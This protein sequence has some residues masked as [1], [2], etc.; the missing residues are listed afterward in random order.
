MAHARREIHATETD[1]ERPGCHYSQ[2]ADFI[3]ILLSRLYLDSAPHSAQFVRSTPQAQPTPETPRRSSEATHHPPIRCMLLLNQRACAS[4]RERDRDLFQLGRKAGSRRRKGAAHGC[5]PS[6]FFA[7]PIKATVRRS[8]RGAAP[9]AQWRRAACSCWRS[10]L[11][12]PRGFLHWS[13]RVSCF[14]AHGSRRTDMARALRSSIRVR[15]RACSTACARG[16]T[17]TERS[18]CTLSIRSRTPACKSCMR[19]RECSWR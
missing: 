10:L 11:R 2:F 13:P 9:R 6:V 18:R 8:P 12:R 15:P 3:L 7:A 1:T 17:L 14:P 19:R 16:L 5:F 4:P